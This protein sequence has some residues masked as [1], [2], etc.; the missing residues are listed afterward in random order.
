MRYRFG[1]VRLRIFLEEKR[2]NL[3]NNVLTPPS[4][5]AEDEDETA[6]IERS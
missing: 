6:M 2:K 5:F 3:S 1:I 4:L